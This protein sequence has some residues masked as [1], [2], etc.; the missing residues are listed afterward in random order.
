[1]AF[2]GAQ[3]LEARDGRL[4]PTEWNDTEHV[5]VTRAFL[6]DPAATLHK[7]RQHRH[8]RT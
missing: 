7:L 4:Q 1:M 8:D 3:I 5:R 6:N 2:P